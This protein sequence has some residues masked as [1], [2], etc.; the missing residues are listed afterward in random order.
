MGRKERVE[1]GRQMAQRDHERFLLNQRLPGDVVPVGDRREFTQQVRDLVAVAGDKVREGLADEG[2]VKDYVKTIKLG[3][4]DPRNKTCLHLYAQVMKLIGEERRVIVEFVNRLGA[5]SEDD[6]RRYV[7]TARSV[8][9]VGPHEGAERCVAYLEAYFNAFPEQRH[10]A[11]K[12]LG[13]AVPV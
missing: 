12:R 10:A 6:L 9:G 4:R 5:R 8:E 13:G 11:I 1:E 2:T 3:I 7:E